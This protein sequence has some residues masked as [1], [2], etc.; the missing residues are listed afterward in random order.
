MEVEG[1]EEVAEAADGPSSTYT[2]IWSPFFLPY[3]AQRAIIEGKRPTCTEVF[4]CLQ[5]KEHA[6]QGALSRNEKGPPVAS[7]KSGSEFCR[8]TGPMVVGK[9]T[10]VEQ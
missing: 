7:G 1:P 2:E 10:R 9:R 8:F 5:Q 4:S 6:S 3:P